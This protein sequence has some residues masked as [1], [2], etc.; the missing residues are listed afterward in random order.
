MAI[1]DILSM[2]KSPKV[3]QHRELNKCMR[4]PFLLI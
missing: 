2:K 1:C 3:K 4:Q